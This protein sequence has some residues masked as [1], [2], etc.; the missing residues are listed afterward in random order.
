MPLAAVVPPYA[1]KVSTTRRN[2][3]MVRDSVMAGRNR[4]NASAVVNAAYAFLWRNLI[5]LLL[6]HYVHCQSFSCIAKLICT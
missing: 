6:L 5:L 2:L 1:G 3:G 4:D